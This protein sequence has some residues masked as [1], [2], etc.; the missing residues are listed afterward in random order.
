MRQDIA[1]TGARSVMGYHLGVHLG[2]LQVPIF[3]VWNSGPGQCY[4]VTIT[5]ASGL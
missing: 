1:Q 2:V 4:K 3:R 5:G